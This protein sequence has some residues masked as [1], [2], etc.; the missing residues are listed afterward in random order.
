[1]LSWA[2]EQPWWVRFGVAVRVPADGPLSEVVLDEMA[3]ALLAHAVDGHA[4][5]DVPAASVEAQVRHADVKLVAISELE[6]VNLL[7]DKERLPFHVAGLTVV[8][9]DNGAGKSGY[10]RVL[11]QL[12]RA[13]APAPTVQPNVFGALTG[14]PAATVELDIDG[15]IHR[16]RWRQGSPPEVQAADGAE[17]GQVL[18]A[19]NQVVVF[20]AACAQT[21]LTTRRELTYVP[22]ALVMLREIA[23]HLAPGLKTRLAARR[24]LLVPPPLDP[25]A[26]GVAPGTSAAAA[27]QGLSAAAKLEDLRRLADLS[28]EETAR[29]NSLDAAATSAAAQRQLRND[30][31]RRVGARIKVLKS[32]TDSLQRAYDLTT[33]TAQ[34][35]LV[36]VANRVVANEDAARL[37]L[38]HDHDPLPG[39]GGAAWR[40]LWDAAR[41]F[42]TTDA[43][44]GREFPVTE[45]AACVLCQQPLDATAAARLQRYEAAVADTAATQAAAARR[46]L[47]AMRDSLSALTLETDVATALAEADDVFQ[48]LAKGL[49]DAVAEVERCR[50]RMLDW[51]DRPVEATRELLPVETEE[52]TADTD[53]R[54]DPVRAALASLDAALSTQTTRLQLLNG[55]TVDLDTELH[56]ERAQLHG[57]RALGA[58]MATVEIHVNALRTL[59]RLDA[60]IGELDT[61]ACSHFAKKLASDLVTD[62]LAASFTEELARLTSAPRA[63]L[64]TTAGRR[65][66]VLHRMQ[67]SGSAADVTD[68]LSEGEQKAV[69]LAG[70]LAELGLSPPGSPVVFDDPVTSLDHLRRRAVADRLAQEARFRQVV[71]FTHDLTFVTRLLQAVEQQG[72]PCW[73]RRLER[74]SDQAGVVLDGLPW[75]GMSVKERLT[76]L[77]QRV[78]EA[79]QVLEQEGR[80]EFDRRAQLIYDDLRATYERAVEE[81]LFNSVVLRTQHEVKTQSLH[82]VEVTADDRRAVD[83]GMTRVS[84]LIAAHDQAAALAEPWPA[85]DQVLEDVLAC[86]R[87]VDTVDARRKLLGREREEAKK[88]RHTG[89]IPQRPP[90]LR[91]NVAAR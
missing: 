87:W 18:A 5:P 14:V 4:L 22:A 78:R 32:V 2:A 42:S 39:V 82:Q 38:R 6:S 28:A 83:Q 80:D 74:W 13:A 17:A 63:T 64:A 88:Q 81:L 20:D 10:T 36:E 71:V 75:A 37:A 90:A 86:R 35:T 67:L 21:A 29:L 55:G 7:R 25:A 19:L 61:T 54:P 51:C 91:D 56:A 66:A 58:G 34:A 79:R 31:G 84:G 89:A 9:G 33:T 47:A 23:D 53:P 85:P 27:L 45:A 76:R 70:F 44:P 30:E 43:Y 46:R 69:S 68:V 26:L 12:V 41:A 1:L 59:R 40:A 72:I 65:G 49:R 73:I 62:Q 11:R 8:Y 3:S 15:H 77:E 60:L 16:V 50:Q 57:R 52:G 24:N 48:Q